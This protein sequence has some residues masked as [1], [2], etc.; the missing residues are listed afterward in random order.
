MR[1]SNR[2]IPKRPH[3]AISNTRRRIR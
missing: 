3:W 1:L 2:Y